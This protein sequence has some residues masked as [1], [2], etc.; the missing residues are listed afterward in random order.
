MIKLLF[1]PCLT[2][3]PRSRAC[4]YVRNP[5]DDQ[6]CCCARSHNSTVFVPLYGRIDTALYGIP[7]PALERQSRRHG[8]QPRSSSAR[9]VAVTWAYRFFAI[10]SLLRGG[11]AR[12]S[13]PL[14]RDR[15]VVGRFDRSECASTNSAAHAAISQIGSGGK[16]W[17]RYWNKEGPVLERVNLKDP[18]R[19]WKELRLQ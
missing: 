17:S 7:L 2:V 11:F 1:A 9:M 15:S 6:P 12:T 3:P 16:R 5:S 13:P 18:S 8:A 4:L 14:R 19:P 10:S